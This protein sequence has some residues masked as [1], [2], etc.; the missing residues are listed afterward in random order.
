MP[1]AAARFDPVRDTQKNF[2]VLLEALS[3]P[4]QLY[5][6]PRVGFVFG[7]AQNRSS[8]LHQLQPLGAVL[9]T[10]LD[11]EVTFCLLGQEDA[12]RDF[13][14]QITDLTSSHSA[15]R[16]HANYVV[17]LQAPDASL[18][19]QLNPGNLLYPDIS[20]T[21]ICLVPDLASRA[22]DRHNGTLLALEGPGVAE[23][24][25]VWVADIDA[26]FFHAL[27]TVN[28]RYPLGIDVIW[29]TPSGRVA[30]LP[31]STQFTLLE[32]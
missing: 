12:V 8:T 25:A 22:P 1:L 23:R 18:I 14:T 26:T 27:S 21:L 4:G 32:G 24:Q 6:L 20:T 7:S 9:A 5:E 13:S 19:S 11:H 2:R 3:R 31:R 10:L 16:E 17:S 30:G 15:G 28:A 29:I